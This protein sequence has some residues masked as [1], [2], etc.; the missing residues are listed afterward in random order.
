LVPD[1]RDRDSGGNV[2]AIASMTYEQLAA[3]L[4]FEPTAV[5]TALTPKEHRYVES[6][7]ALA[8]SSYAAAFGT[9]T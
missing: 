4:G 6:P 2:R 9:S 7:A 8:L 3:A 5:V 1:R